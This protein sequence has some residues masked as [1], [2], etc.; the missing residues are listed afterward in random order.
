MYV[1]GIDVGGT[2]TDCVAI[3]DAGRVSIDKAFTTPDDLS[4]GILAALQNLSSSIAISVHDLLGEAQVFALGTT[5]MTN[6]VVARK[7]APVGVLISKG[8]ED[9]MRIGRIM[10]RTEGLRE[11]Q[12]YDLSIWNKPEPLA[13]AM[14]PCEE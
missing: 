4:Q 8:H 2:F 9:V 14:E 1:I 3:D 7:G 12:R 5:S 10:A 6:R 13:A 11:D